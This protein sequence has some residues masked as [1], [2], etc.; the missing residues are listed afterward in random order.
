MN[1][2]T[3]SEAVI[4]E[5]VVIGPDEFRKVMCDYCVGLGYYFVYSADGE[6]K[7]TADCIHCKGSGRR[8]GLAQSIG[9]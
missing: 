2:I 8:D 1:K 7:G 5:A 9:E 4:I 6:L 3:R